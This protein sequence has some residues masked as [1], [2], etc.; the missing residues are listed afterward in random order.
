MNQQNA[1][2]LRKRL[3]EIDDELRDVAS[4]DFGRR[5]ELLTESD[6]V[7]AA[8]EE[9]VGA[10]LVEAA[11]DWA[12]RAGRKGSHEVDYEARKGMIVSPNEGGGN[13]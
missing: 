11:A 8:L 5:H 12:E 2:N 10:D 7:R 3:V 13:I 9:E 1:E 6:E 4:D